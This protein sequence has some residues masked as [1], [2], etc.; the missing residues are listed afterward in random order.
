[1]YIK[2]LSVP[3]CST[4]TP[5]LNIFSMA[6]KKKEMASSIH[7]LSLHR[8]VPAIFNTRTAAKA[9][10]S[11]T[12]GK[13]RSEKNQT[14]PK[15]RYILINWFLLTIA[16]CGITLLD[17]VIFCILSYVFLQFDFQNTLN[18]H[19]TRSDGIR[20]VERENR[21]MEGGDRLKVG[22]KKEWNKKMLRGEEPWMM[23]DAN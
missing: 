8:S 19:N 3:W 16:K 7:H 6:K 18:V 11:V 13:R 5:R 21:S 15:C 10:R 14:A 17:T 2:F 1:M 4:F 9:A 12:G 22:G 23:Y 20:P